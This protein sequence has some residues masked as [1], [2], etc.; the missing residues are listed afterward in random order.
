MI[1][2]GVIGYHNLRGA[3]LVRVL[4]N[5]PDVELVWVRGSGTDVGTRLDHV[6]PG[7]IGECDLLIE[8]M[9]TVDDVDLLY[10]CGS[11]DEVTAQLKRLTLPD[12]LHVIDL[13][14]CHNHDH[15][16][17]SAWKYGMN[18]MQRRVI[19]H[20]AH[21]VTVPGN[22][23]EASLLAVMPMARNLLIN[24]PLTLEVAIGESALCNGG[25]TLDG[26]TVSQWA[27]D[28][29][30]EVS[31]ALSQCQSGFSQPV[32]LTVT[33]LAERRTLAVAARF[34]CGVDSEMIRRLYEQYYDDHNFVFIVD[35]PVAAA[36]VENTNKCLIQLDKDERSGELTVHA[37]MDVLLKGCSGNA[38]HAMNLM[39]GLHERAGLSL[40]GTGC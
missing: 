7:I 5:H 22:A 2:V 3:E 20:D 21:W 27:E 15:G 36:D 1:K 16:P 28:Q 25:Q 33:P 19:V 4:I 8:P 14:G 23:A 32:T 38:V 24:S 37:V 9:D 30:R 12:E 31:L 13:S 11:R 35:C 29:Q 17:E 26:M 10:L 6:V 34:K 18:E 40:K 39:F